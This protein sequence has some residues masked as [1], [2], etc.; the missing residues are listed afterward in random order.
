MVARGSQKAAKGQPFTCFTF[1]LRQTQLQSWSVRVGAQNCCIA[2]IPILTQKSSLQDQPLQQPANICRVFG[3]VQ[4]S[5]CCC[6]FFFFKIRN[7]SIC[8]TTC[9]KNVRVSSLHVVPDLPFGTISWVIDISWNCS[10]LVFVT[11]SP[12][13]DLSK[14]DGVDR[15]RFSLFRGDV[16][17]GHIV[18]LGPL[19]H[20]RHQ[21]CQAFLA[22]SFKQLSFATQLCLS[23]SKFPGSMASD[24][25][26]R[27]QSSAPR[28][29]TCSGGGAGW[30]GFQPT[31]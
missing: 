19:P 31:D 5:L 3:S 24:K 26:A 21:P 2:H 27:R 14:V 8:Q 22:K 15:P 29:W 23:R 18:F 12:R 9:C 1:D 4:R 25:S 17:V 28:P 10:W 20:Q 16:Y 7:T 13:R 11:E 6:C 30:R